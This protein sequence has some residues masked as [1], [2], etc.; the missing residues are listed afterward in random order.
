MH[1]ACFLIDNSQIKIFYFFTVNIEDTAPILNKAVQP[2]KPEPVRVGDVDKL[3][4]N[5]GK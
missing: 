4:N 2:P 1:C 3:K 5:A